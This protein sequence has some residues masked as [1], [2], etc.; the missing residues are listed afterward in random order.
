MAKGKGKSGG[1][2]KAGGS[3]GGKTGGSYGQTA[4]PKTSGL[5]LSPAK[6]L[7]GKVPGGKSR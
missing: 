2:M 1:Y 3:L 5:I 4:S 6:P 7:G